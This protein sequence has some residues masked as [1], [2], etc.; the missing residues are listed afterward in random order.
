MKTVLSL[1]K[2]NSNNEKLKQLADK[3]CNHE[4]NIL[5]SGWKKVYYGMTAEGFEGKNYS[6]Q[7]SVQD[8]HEQV[9]EFYREK[10]QQLLKLQERFVPGYEPI[11]WQIDFKS[12][13]RFNAGIHHSKLQYGVISGVDAKVSADLGRLY[14]LIPLAKAYHRFED[15]RYKNELLAQLADFTAFNPVEYG[16][17]WRANMNVAIRAANIIAA[18]DILGWDE[19]DAKFADIINETIIDHGQYIMENL[20]FPEEHFHPN[21]FIA[22]L[23]GLLMVA[24]ATEHKEWF[25]YATKT[26]SE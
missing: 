4:F 6:T 17:A 15:P 9:P 1:N 16:A 19:I 3:Y 24:C 18:L 22:N 7:F 23:T 8:A 12:G 25:D 5:G 13:A 11:D 14:Q 26:L 21:H 20:E 2:S 10:H